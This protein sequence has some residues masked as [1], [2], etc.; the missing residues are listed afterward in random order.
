MSACH[1]SSDFFIAYISP[2]AEG[3]IYTSPGKSEAASLG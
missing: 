3:E 1:E 2:F